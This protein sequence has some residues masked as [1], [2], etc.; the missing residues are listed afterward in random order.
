MKITC[1][2]AMDLV[3]IY[4]SG[5]ASA[6]TKNAVDEHLK[7]CRS[8]REFYKDYRSDMKKKKIEKQTPNLRFEANGVDEEV[9]SRTLSSLSKRLRK[10]QVLTTTIA[11][12]TAVFGL[13]AFLYD[14][15]SDYRKGK[16]F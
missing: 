10:R 9:I 8:C 5:A 11:A 12:A 15:I 2:L 3:D 7:T 6:D 16:R 14:L 1:D 13:A 4:S